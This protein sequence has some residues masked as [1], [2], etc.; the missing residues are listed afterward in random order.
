MVRIVPKLSTEEE[1]D[2]FFVPVLLPVNEDTTKAFDETIRAIKDD[3]KIIIANDD[4]QLSLLRRSQERLA[5]KYEKNLFLDERARLR[6]VI[7]SCCG[8]SFAQNR[9]GVLLRRLRPGMEM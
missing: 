4:Q 7:E 2:A 9:E 5:V 8:I 3:L 1:W 6:T